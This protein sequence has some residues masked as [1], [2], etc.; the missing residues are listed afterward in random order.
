M[1]YR[2]LLVPQSGND[3]DQEILENAGR[4]ADLFK[5]HMEVLFVR[6]DPTSSVPLLMG[7]G[8][9]ANQ[10]R[11]S[12]VKSHREVWDAVE[13]LVRARFEAYAATGIVPAVEALSGP[14]AA[15]MRF[16]SQTGDLEE[17]L[18]RYARV[19]DM[20]IFHSLTSGEPEF[21]PAVLEKILLSSGRP[22]LYL[23][24]G[25]VNFDGALTVGIAW[26]GRA[27]AARAVA[28]SLPFIQLADKV[29]IVSIENG[30]A[31][32]AHPDD[33]RDYIACLGLPV[34][35]SSVTPD[36]QRTELKLLE[37]I[38][39]RHWGLLVMGG[40]AHSRWQEMLISGP[41]RHLLRHATIPLIQSH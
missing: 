23:P 14:G 5:A 15:S 35:A 32:Q 33:L 19:C 40:F 34:E 29:E 18:S 16:I 6:P 1:S 8:D 7:A 10:L 21:P 26:D 41:T 37:L 20:T 3:K 31:T 28:Q 4:L 2:R 27:E 22:C 36:F 11:A 30:E 17:V 13:V 9:V 38:E 12:M 25:P 39:Q 24:G